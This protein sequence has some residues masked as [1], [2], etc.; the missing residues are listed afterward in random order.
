MDYVDGRGISCGN[1]VYFN[2]IDG[3]VVMLMYR[4]VPGVAMANRDPNVVK[5]F[6]PAQWGEINDYLLGVSHDEESVEETPEEEVVTI[7]NER[8]DLSVSSMPKMTEAILPENRV[9][10]MTKDEV[11]EKH[12]PITGTQNE[13]EEDGKE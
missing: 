8:R 1:D 5:S 12:D 3:R 4:D 2:Y 11:Q 9:P 7:H 6:S 13:E 10:A